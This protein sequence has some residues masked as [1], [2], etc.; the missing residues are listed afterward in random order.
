MR[1][2]NGEVIFIYFGEAKQIQSGKTLLTVILNPC[3]EVIDSY[4]SKKIVYCGEINY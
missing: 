3:H 4:F 1:A 2:Q